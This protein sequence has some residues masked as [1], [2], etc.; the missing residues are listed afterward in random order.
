MPSILTNKEFGK[1]PTLRVAGAVSTRTIEHPNNVIEGKGKVVTQRGA[2]ITAKEV[3]EMMKLQVPYPNLATNKD[4]AAK[5][6]QWAEEHRRRYEETTEEKRDQWRAIQYMLRGFTLSRRFMQS[7]IHVG[8]L[9]KALETLTPLIEE[10]M[11]QYDPAFAVKGRDQIDRDQSELIRQFL[12]YQLYAARWPH[13]VQPNVRAGL[14]YG[15]SALKVYWDVE[16]EHRVRRNVDVETDPET[17]EVTY[18]YEILEEEQVKWWGPR[19]RIVDPLDLFVDTRSIDPPFDSL[20]IGDSQ[21]MTFEEMKEKQALGIFE[22]VDELK[23]REPSPERSYTHFDKQVRNLE[24][25]YEASNLTPPEGTP[26][27]H[28]VTEC[29]GLFDPYGRGDAREY[30]VTIVDDSVCVRCQENPHDQKH[31]PYAVAR[32]GKDPFELLTVGPLDHAVKTNIEIDEHRNLALRGHALSVSGIWFLPEGTD[33]PDNMFDIEPGST[34]ESEAAPTFIAPKPVIGEM[35]ALEATLRRDIEEY[36]GAYRIHEMPNQTATE[37]ER[38]IQVR[39]MRVRGYVLAFTRQFEDGL[40]IMHNLNRQ[41]VTRDM[42]FRVIGAGAK[43]LSEYGILSPKDIDTDVDF[44][45]KGPSNLRQMGMRATNISTFL[46]LA[47]P[48]MAKYP[49]AVDEVGLLKELWSELVGNR[50]GDRYFPSDE[51]YRDLLDQ[52]DENTRLYQGIPIAVSD[53]DD[54]EEH[55]KKMSP[56]LEDGEEREKLSPSAKVVFDEH[57]ATHE[58]KLRGQ[59]ARQRAAAQQNPVGALPQG[60][61]MDAG[62]GTTGQR[63]DLNGQQVSQTPPNEASGPPSMFSAASADRMQPFSQTE[64]RL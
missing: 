57:A 46:N 13:L 62:R 27:R 45:F 20:I 3:R 50:A 18:D 33:A 61:Q 7:D 36:T 8:E 43:G 63:Q 30:V 19:I 51:D 1:N 42:K 6:L 26:R 14:S 9:Y 22:N 12:E 58:Y 17:G 16:L 10:A 31:R 25:L 11:L 29:W 34:F 38:K 15:I 56:Y 2:P 59:E 55:L 48:I 44:E 4:V 47:Y 52:Q 39:N 5:A 21:Q 53:L 23:D 28:T 32:L 35:N 64:N 37:V 54:H 49:G 40:K 24:F 60:G 41:F